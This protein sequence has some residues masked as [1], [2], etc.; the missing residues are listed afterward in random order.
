[1]D[2][3]SALQPVQ[4]RSL[5][6]NR[7][8]TLLWIGQLV[9]V[10][11]D[12]LH[13][14]ALLALVSSLTANDLGQ[15]GMV[16]AT[17][18]VPSLLFGVFAGALVD[19]WKRRNVMLASDLIRVVLV[20]A[21]PT[22]ARIDLIWVYVITFL[23]TTVS[24]FFRPAKEG[25]IPDIVPEHGL[26]TANSLSSATDTTIEVLG[27][28][29]AGALVGGLAGSLAGGA[30]IELAFYIDAGTYLFSAL[31][32]YQMSIASE[33]A[34][35]SQGGLRSLVRMVIDGLRFVRSSAPLLTNTL[36]IAMGALVASGSLTLAYGYAT[37]VAH[38]GPFGYSL[39]EAALGLGNVLGALWV[40]RWG[41][42]YRKGRLVLGGLLMLGL[43]NV[44]LAISP[45]MWF[46]TAMMAGAGVANML[47]FI[48]SIT[49]VQQLAPE[50]MRGRVLS[51]R[52]SLTMVSFIASNALLGIGAMLYGVQPMLALSGGLLLAVGVAAFALPSVREV[53]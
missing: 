26:M 40:G 30:G 51:F 18:G 33:H 8:Y 24:L 48:P 39:L 2:D 21:I 6:R 3:A 23:L 9:S 1:M 42:R 22:L 47:F 29:L 37:E 36:L 34:E 19:R 12:R 11:G 46:A 35:P 31:M 44:L 16:I 27:Y 49:L 50:G 52:S 4:Y 7:N 5:L 20:A 14:I 32:I 10:F 45:D 43:T 28:P 53:D 17:I 13:Q 25:I 41:G 38:S 15:I